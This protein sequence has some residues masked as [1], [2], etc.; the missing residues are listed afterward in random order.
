MPHTFPV[1]VRGVHTQNTH[2]WVAQLFILPSIA[3]SRGAQERCKCLHL[4]VW[5]G[6]TYLYTI[7]LVRIV[8]LLYTFSFIFELLPGL[9]A[10][11]HAHVTSRIVVRSCTK[12]SPQYYC[13][14]KLQ[15]LSNAGYGYSLLEA[16]P[17]LLVH[18]HFRGGLR[19][20]CVT[21]HT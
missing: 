21:L 7:H 8:Q 17:L 13:T 16:L 19:P 9:L 6:G 4:Y 12:T 1:Y 20:T 2:L 14:Q 3:Q 5:G 15:N 11:P 18:V 10:P